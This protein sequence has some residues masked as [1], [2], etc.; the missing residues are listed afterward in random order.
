MTFELKW[1]DLINGRH[2][3]TIATVAATDRPSAVSRLIE[4]RGL[5]GLSG[6]SG[7]GGIATGGGYVYWLAEVAA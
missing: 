7:V 6:W 5:C 2:G 4:D 3:V 1:S